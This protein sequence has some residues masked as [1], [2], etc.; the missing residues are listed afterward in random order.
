M[1]PMWLCSAKPSHTYYHLHSP[2]KSSNGSHEAGSLRLSVSSIVSE[3]HS[4]LDYNLH[5][6]MV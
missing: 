2:F 5:G 3:N 1:L 6:A 4:H